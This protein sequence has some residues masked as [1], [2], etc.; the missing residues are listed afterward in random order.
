MYTGLLRPLKYVREAVNNCVKHLRDNFQGKYSLPKQDPN[1]FMYEHDPE[2]D[3]SGPFDPEQ[4]FYSQSLIVVI[5]WMVEISRIVI[6][7]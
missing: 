1:P 4:A 5:S 3:I 2:I 6:E 7:T